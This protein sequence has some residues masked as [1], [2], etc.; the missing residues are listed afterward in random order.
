MK[1][2]TALITGASS[3]IGR[4]L[5]FL[6][7]EEGYDL[8]LIARRPAL[9][10]DLRTAIEASFK[11]SVYALSKDLSLVS[12]SEDILK[13]LTGRNIFPEILINNA[14]FGLYGEFIETEWAKEKMMIDLNVSALVHLT[15]LFLP[16]M[17]SNRSGRIMNVA[18]TA[19]FQP[20]PNMAVYF[21]S[22]AFVLSFSEA[23]AE[24]LSGSG[25]TVT[26]LCPGPT[27]SEFSEVASMKNSNLFKGNIP[28]ARE[29]AL[30]GFK[31]MMK[32]QRV[33]IHGTGN[34]IMVNA[35]RFTPRR[36]VTRIVKYLQ[37]KPKND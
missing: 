14:G 24:E 9:L 29:V 33:A 37:G 23:I 16:G 17:I 15:K 35:V 7:A 27:S 26:A 8:V 2:R 6:L 19:A 21:A 13:D 22:K 11:V 31:A 34:T 10:D 3:G 4:E 18:S 5:A 20:G 12:S 28:T 30:F 36:L 25:V 32:G 1:K